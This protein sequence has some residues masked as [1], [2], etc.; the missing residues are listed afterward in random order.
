MGGLITQGR[1]RMN[2][3]TGHLLSVSLANGH[4]FSLKRQENLSLQTQLCKTLLLSSEISPQ[5][6]PPPTPI[7]RQAIPKTGQECFCSALY[8][9]GTIPPLNPTRKLTHFFLSF[10]PFLQE[11]QSGALDREREA[12]DSSGGG[13]TEPSLRTEMEE[14]RRGKLCVGPSN[15]SSFRARAHVCSKQHAFALPPYLPRCHPAT[16]PVRQQQEQI[17]STPVVGKSAIYS[18][19]SKL[20]VLY[21]N[22]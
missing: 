16:L 6:V 15:N 5:N 10:V 14:G 19:V 11:E 1:R 18:Q 20:N 4:S 3:R 17:Q 9:G 13:R 12:V 22:L 7:L 21:E 2:E 8:Y